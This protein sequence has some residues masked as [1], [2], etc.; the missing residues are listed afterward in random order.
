MCQQKLVRPYKL[1]LLKSTL[2]LGL[3]YQ[4]KNV[5]I[6]VLKKIG[7]LALGL[8]ILSSCNKMKTD[9]QGALVP[10]TVIEDLS[11]PQI[12]IDGVILHSETYGDPSDPMLVVLHGG[13]GGDY[14]GM[15]NFKELAD[16][17]MFVVF[18]DQRGSGLSQRLDQSSYTE[19]QVFINELEGVIDHYRNNNAQK[20]VLAGHSWGAMLAAAY[21]NQHPNEIDGVIFVEPGGFNW[22]Q[23]KSYTKK[24]SQLDVLSEF[25]NDYVYQDQIITGDDHNTLDYKLALSTAANV[26]TG[27]ENS[28]AFWRYGAICNTA[29]L[30]LAINYPEQVNFTTHLNSYT[31]KTLFVYSELNT[32][33]GMDHAK[34]VSSFLPNVQLAEIKGCG[35]EIPQYGWHNLYPLIKTYLNEIL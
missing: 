11:I 25:T 10:L 7:R 9:K 15:L 6:M 21:I 5:E 18:Y 20:I 19:V 27:D 28:A 30:Q 13:P 12:N 2:F 8:I 34:S 3:L 31:T 29:S 4:I 22:E 35:H 33:Y 23:T 26:H 16:D 14:R 17:D 1:T 32:A 24:S